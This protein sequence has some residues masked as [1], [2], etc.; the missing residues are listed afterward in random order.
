MTEIILQYPIILYILI[1]LSFIILPIVIIMAVVGF[2]QGR[3]FST[4]LF[5]IGAKIPSGPSS[6]HSHPADPQ[7]AEEQM[8]EI[9][10]RVRSKL[11]EFK[12]E[13]GLSDQ[14][15]SIRPP[16]L[17]GHTIDLF[18]LRVEIGRKVREIVLSHGGGWAGSSLATFETFI[19]LAIQHNLISRQLA[20]DIQGFEFLIKPGI[21][22]DEIGNEQYRDATQLA[23]K[24]LRQLDEVEPGPLQ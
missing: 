6:L 22:G 1:A 11:E 14:A 18:S 16:N 23:S 8:D 7:I 19:E 13:R 4:P 20:Q 12:E 24:I 9:I 3:E 2:I 5:R 15:L 21:Y 17:P 10:E